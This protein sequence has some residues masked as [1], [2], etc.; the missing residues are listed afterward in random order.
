M[1]PPAK[2]KDVAPVYPASALAARVQGT[3]ILEAT[4]GVDGRV[5]DVKVLRSIPMFDQAAIDAVMQW[6]Y[7]PTVLNGVAVP[8][9]MTVTVPFTL[10]R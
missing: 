5:S 4:I 3:V 1:K 8:V 6:E 7:T 9:I 10:D 2:V